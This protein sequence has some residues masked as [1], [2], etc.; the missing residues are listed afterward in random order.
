MDMLNIKVNGLPIKSYKAVLYTHL[1][2]HETNE[3][4][5]WCFVREKKNLHRL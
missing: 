4:R 2:A 5:V 3:N 1:R